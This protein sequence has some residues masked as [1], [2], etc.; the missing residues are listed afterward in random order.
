MDLADLVAAILFVGVIAYAIFGG[1]DFGSGAWDLT[2]GDTD[3][4]GDARRLID[5]AI[6]PV[7]EANHVWLV[8]VL[9]FLWTGFPS[10]FATIMQELAVPFW[11]VGLGIVLRGSGFA[12]RRYAPDFRWARLAGIVFASS[13]V[14]TPFFMG[15]IAGAVASGRVGD[16]V[17]DGIEWLS[18]TSLLGGMLAVATCAFLAGVFLLPILLKPFYRPFSTHATENVAVLIVAG[19]LVGIG[20]RIANG[21]TIQQRIYCRLTRSRWCDL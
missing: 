13:S 19:L 8:F 4:G 14:L 10:A 16:G 17:D 9:V 6:G 12:F 5:A 20:T 18:P 1:A 7:W 15:T 2:A 11:L 21:C 3:E